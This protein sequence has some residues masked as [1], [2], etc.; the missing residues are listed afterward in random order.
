ML[1]SII[2][3]LINSLYWQNI[4]LLQKYT[5]VIM[6]REM[7]YHLLEMIYI[8]YLYYTAFGRLFQSLIVRGKKVY[9]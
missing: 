7:Q 9:L 1:P 6:L 4:S 8:I 2:N 5:S 3:K